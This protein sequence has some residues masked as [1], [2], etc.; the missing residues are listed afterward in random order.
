MIFK[1]TV[2][3]QRSRALALM[4]HFRMSEMHDNQVDRIEVRAEL[5]LPFFFFIYE[6][7]IFS[8]TQR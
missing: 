4:G 7:M 8:H 2:D 3:L 1:K 6:T 5:Y